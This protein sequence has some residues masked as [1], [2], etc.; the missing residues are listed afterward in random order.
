[1]LKTTCYEQP[2]NERIRALLRLEFSFQQVEHAIANSNVA[3]WSSRMALQGLFDIFDLTGRNEFKSELLKELERHAT[4]LG[5]LRQTPHVDCTALDRVLAEIAHVTYRIHN[6]LD[7]WSMDAVRK[8]DFLNAVHKRN[9]VS[10]GVC[11]FDLPALHHWLQHDHTV[12]NHHLQDWLEPFVPMREAILLILQL[13]RQSG[14]PHP[15]VAQRGFLQ[16]GLDSTVSNQLIRVLL[17]SNASVFPEISASRHRFTIR[18]LEQSD[19]N[20]RAVQSMAD[21]A[22][23]LACCAI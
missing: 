22:F 15:E 17:P 21:V 12:R 20:C 2:L 14:S 18:F 8:T 6:H 4:T 11:S 1:M 5:R 10:I 23:D 16:R 9:R 19:P 3:S 7:N 13:I